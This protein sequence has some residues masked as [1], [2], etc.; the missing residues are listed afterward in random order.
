M[1]AAVPDFLAM[2]TEGQRAEMLAAGCRPEEI[3]AL[4]D[5]FRKAR[6]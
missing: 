5:M 4:L 6:E 3:E 1:Q 2:P